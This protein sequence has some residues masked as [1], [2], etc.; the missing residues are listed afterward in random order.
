MNNVFYKVFNR[1]TVK[2]SYSAMP[3]MEHIKG[4]NQKVLKGNT[5][6]KTPTS[7]CR[8]QGQLPLKWTIFNQQ[9]CI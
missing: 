1:N 6:N 8:K 4:N 9:H 5:L 2:I 3:N 7:N